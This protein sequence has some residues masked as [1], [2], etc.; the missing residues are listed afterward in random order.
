[1]NDNTMQKNHPK[2]FWRRQDGKGIVRL[3][4]AGIAYAACFTLT[5]IALAARE[6]VIVVDWN[7][8]GEWQAEKWLLI[9]LTVF[10]TLAT[11]FEF[12]RYTEA[13]E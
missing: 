10:V 7:H 2:P 3:A 11:A 4:T 13:K 12:S 1:M 5:S 8:Y 9:A 6:G